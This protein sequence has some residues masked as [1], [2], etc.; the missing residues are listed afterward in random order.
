MLDYPR[1]HV[2]EWTVAP[3]PPNSSVDP[4]LAA[5]HGY[6]F[7]NNVQ[8]DTYIFVGMATI[9]A[10]TRSRAEFLRLTGPCPLL[11]DYA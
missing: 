11:P 3:I 4:E 10:W 6:D 8:G 1:F 2:P 5:T 7:R 9:D